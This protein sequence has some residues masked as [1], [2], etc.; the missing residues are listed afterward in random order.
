MCNPYAIAALAG[1]QMM[2]AKRTAQSAGAYAQAAHNANMQQ[3]KDNRAE[4]ILEAKQKGNMIAQTFMEK[5]A[6]NRALL[7]SNG[8]SSSMSVS[9]AFQYSKS[10]FKTELNSVAIEESRKQSGLAAKAQDSRLQLATTKAAAKSA[11][12]SAYLKAATTAAVSLNG[13]PD[14]KKFWT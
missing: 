1:M 7:S 12:N 5:Q 9:A 8:I 13:L 14:D 6:T 4:V 2:Q 10:N 3:I 11:R